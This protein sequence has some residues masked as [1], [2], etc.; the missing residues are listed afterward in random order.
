M[1]LCRCLKEH[2]SPLRGGYNAY[3]NPLGYPDT[4][5]V[6]GIPSCNNV[7]IIWL[8]EPELEAYRKGQR[9]SS[10]QCS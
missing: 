7:G 1:A 6:C 10:H 5:L 9:I 4:S 3:V 2:S 8:K